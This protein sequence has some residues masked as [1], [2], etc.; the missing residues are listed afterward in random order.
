MNQLGST[1]LYLGGPAVLLDCTSQIERQKFNFVSDVEL[2]HVPSQMHTLCINY[3]NYIYLRGLHVPSTWHAQKDFILNKMAGKE[4]CACS[5]CVETTKYTCLRCHEYYCM[6]CSV[7]KND[8]TVAGWRG[9]SMVAYC[10]PC[11]QEKMER[12]M[13]DDKDKCIEANV[14]SSSPK[15]RNDRENQEQR[16]QLDSRDTVK[17]YAFISVVN[18]FQT[19]QMAS[20]IDPFVHA[21]VPHKAS[22][23]HSPYF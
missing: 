10:E 3:I 8:E 22:I 20:L 5:S 17:R 13:N 4:E 15:Q 12:E 7:F 11:F 21:V 9:G 19:V 2:L 14:S 18:L 16:D 23:L 6:R 1:D